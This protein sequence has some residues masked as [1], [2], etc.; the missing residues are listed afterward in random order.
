MKTRNLKYSLLPAIAILVL[1]ITSC[2]KIKDAAQ[3]DLLY[4]VPE[5]TI[6]V[7][8]VI[9]QHAGNEVLILAKTISINLDSIKRKHNLSAFKDAKFDFI[10]LLADQPENM[11]L[12]WI[13]T[14]RAT[15]TAPGIS[16]T[17]VASYTAAAPTGKPSLDM[18]IGGNS[19]TSFMME[20]NFT[21]KIYIEVTPPLP[22]DVMKVLLD[23]RIRITVQPI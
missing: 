22:A 3:F 16:E 1:S 23:S 8:S 12:D 19:I 10:R 2:Q 9:V 17:D 13:K 4:N 7:D 21:L 11:N 20:Q 6:T 18:V 14:L 15:V 5:S